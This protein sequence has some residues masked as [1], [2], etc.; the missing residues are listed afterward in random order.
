ML[1]DSSP[2][3]TLLFLTYQNKKLLSGH[4]HELVETLQEHH[5]CGH[6][7]CYSIFISQEMSHF[8]FVPILKI[9]QFMECEF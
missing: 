7:N 4:S 1:I 5:I 6:L 2:S 3:N 8:S 9:E